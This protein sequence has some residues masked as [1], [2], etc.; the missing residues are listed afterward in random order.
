MIKNKHAGSQS[1][2]Q[3]WPDTYFLSYSFILFIL[4][5]DR[6]LLSSNG[7][8]CDTHEQLI[9]S[10]ALHIYY[11]AFYRMPLFQRKDLH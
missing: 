1:V 2:G 10:K 8:M 5:M 6:L 4:S 9:A 7:C 3:I 11:L